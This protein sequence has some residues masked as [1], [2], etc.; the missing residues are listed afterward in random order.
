MKISKGIFTFSLL[1]TTSMAGVG[2]L[3]VQNL[4]LSSFKFDL[5]PLKKLQ[6]NI[7]LNLPSYPSQSPFQAYKVTST[8]LE[9]EVRV[10]ETNLEETLNQ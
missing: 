1:V 6:E 10:V 3:N 8:Q 7:H 2:G 5:S 9:K 4:K